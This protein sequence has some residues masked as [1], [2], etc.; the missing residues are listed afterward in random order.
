MLS[1]ADTVVALVIADN[2]VL[3]EAIGQGGDRLLVSLQKA[4]RVH[5]L[6]GEVIFYTETYDVIIEQ[7]HQ[8]Q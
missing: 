4:T 3:A 2:T 8:Q 5:V 7:Q 1:K 6:K